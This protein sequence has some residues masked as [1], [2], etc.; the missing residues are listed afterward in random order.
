MNLLVYDASAK[1]PSGILNG[2][3]NQFGDFD[4]CLD[5]TSNQKDFQ[6]QY[7]LAYIQ[8]FTPKN[9]KVLEDLRIK[10]LSFD[11]FKNDFKDV[12]YGV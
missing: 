10:V 1:L 6:G 12:S 4:Q 9:D 7:C 3:I 11:S 5:V 2:N 8:I